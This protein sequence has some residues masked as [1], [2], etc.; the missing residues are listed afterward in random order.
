MER[1]LGKLEL[2]SFHAAR[3][4]DLIVGIGL[5]KG[6]GLGLGQPNYVIRSSSIE[7]RQLRVN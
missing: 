5:G 4:V 1:R 6:L 3:P 7:T 2:T